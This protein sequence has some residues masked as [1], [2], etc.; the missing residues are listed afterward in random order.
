[1]HRYGYPIMREVGEWLALQE[2]VPLRE[3]VG[4]ARLNQWIC[5]SVAVRHGGGRAVKSPATAGGLDE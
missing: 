5:T 4:V 2:I 1:M 3:I